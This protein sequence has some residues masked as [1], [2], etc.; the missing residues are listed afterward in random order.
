MFGLVHGYFLNWLSYLTDISN[1]FVFDSHPEK[2]DF[3]VECFWKFHFIKIS[4]LKWTTYLLNSL[5]IVYFIPFF[6]NLT[7]PLSRAM[8]KLAIRRISTIFPKIL[9]FW[10]TTFS[11][12]SCYLSLLPTLSLDLIEVKNLFT[13]NLRVEDQSY[14]Q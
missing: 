11:S 1:F 9:I 10:T 13:F 14:V 2:S 7:W 8:E 3:K 5:L 4:L 12:D 6:L